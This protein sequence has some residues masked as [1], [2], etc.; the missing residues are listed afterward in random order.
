M[1]REIDE[2]M[3]HA[4]CLLTTV[5]V[6]HVRASHVARICVTQVSVVPFVEVILLLI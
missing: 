5:G 3:A 4:A 1:K 6:S 2:D